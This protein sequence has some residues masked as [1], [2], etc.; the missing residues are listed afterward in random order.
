MHN[1]ITLLKVNANPGE[2]SPA[3]EAV[4]AKGRVYHHGTFHAIH[5]FQSVAED[6][7]IDPRINAVVSREILPW[8]C[9]SRPSGHITDAHEYRPGDTNLQFANLNLRR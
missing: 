1:V 2:E 6:E 3:I 7:V 8:G 5:N 4:G 9:V